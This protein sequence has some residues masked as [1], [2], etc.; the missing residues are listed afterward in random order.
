MTPFVSFFRALGVGLVA[1]ALAAPSP[2]QEGPGERRTEDA[3]L[4]PDAPS[5]G[6]AF[7]SAVAVSGDRAIVTAPNADCFDGE[8]CGEAYVLAFD[9]SEWTQET[10]LTASDASSSDFF[11]SSVDLEGNRAILGAYARGCDAGFQCGAVYVFEFDGTVWDET[12]I[13]TASDADEGGLFGY[14]ISLSG[15][16]ALVGAPVADCPTGGSCGAAYAY[17]FDGEQWN[18]EAILTP[19]DLEPG[20]RF[21]FSVSLEGDRAVVSAPLADC[22]AGENCG[23]AYVFSRNAAGWTEDT[24]LVA[25]DF[26]ADALFGT[27]V[28]LSGDRAL[29]GARSLDSESASSG[30]AYVFQE[31]GGR[32]SQEAQLANPG[33]PRFGASVALYGDRALVGTRIGVCPEGAD[34]EA[35]YSFVASDGTWSLEHEFAPTDPVENGSF[36]YDVVLSESRA[37]VGAPQARCDATTACGAVYLYDLERLNV[38]SE[39]APETGLSLA[40]RPHPLG[41]AGTAEVD[42]PAAGRARLTLHDA[43]GREVAVLHDAPLAAGRHE[44]PLDVARLA[45]GVYVLRWVSGSEAVAR[46]LTVA[47]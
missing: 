24:R 41:R 10:I 9:G 29:V 31:A 33:I 3:R 46:T 40:V 20:D 12:A 1:L 13:L 18:E 32:W 26:G 5:D 45:A 34:C 38:A 17:A 43:L 16:V 15:D 47:R 21:G 39:A 14:T 2:A 44:I 6:M 4:A 37:V 27:S 22:S 30:S 36:G 23:A 8:R 19:S 35:A 28:A 7:G 25:R 42:V 11:G